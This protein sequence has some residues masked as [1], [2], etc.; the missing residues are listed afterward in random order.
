[1]RIPLDRQSD[2]PL[3]RQIEAFLRQGILSGSLPTDTRLPASR[4][5][6]GDL[7]VNRITV[8]N[9]YAELEADGLIAS[10]VGS[11]TYVLS[12]YPLLPQTSDEHRAS[13]PLWQQDVLARSE[14]ARRTTP[15]AMLKAAGHPHP[16]NFASGIGDPHLFPVKDFRKVI[17]TVLQRDDITAL[18]YGENNGYAPLRSTIA[19]IL[20]N[21]GLQVSPGNVMITS[22]SQQALAL[23]AQ[24]LLRPGDV[25]L[26]ESPTHGGVLGLFRFLDLK[27]VGIPTDENGMQVEKL[28]R[29][30][31][32]HHPRL[33]YT[34]P[35]FHNPT[36]V[37]MSGQRR[38]QLLALA[39]SY[40]IPILEDDFV[41]D[42]RY[43]GRG[44]PT[45]KALD[46]SGSVIYVSTFS[47]MLMPGLRVGFLVAHGPIYDML[48]EFKRSND[49]ATSSGHWKPMLRLVDTRLICAAAARSTANGAT[50]YWQRSA[51]TCLPTC[52]SF[53]PKVGC[54]SGCGFRTSCQPMPCCRWPAGRVSLLRLE[55][56][57]SWRL[58]AARMPCVSTSLSIRPRTPKKG[59]GGWGEPSSGW[60]LVDE[61]AVAWTSP[62]AR[63]LSAISLS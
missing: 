5:L 33:I 26:V 8:D 21:Q 30:L 9:A 51:S 15:D 55:G 31:Q 60:L 49:V 42:L 29:L 43:E 32:Q 56:T 54:L 11:G 39:D 24:L 35:N 62:Y 12:P 6:A 13:W 19:H 27:I 58:P 25:V 20:A 46:A 34:I 52:M 4:Q 10:R 14:A 57:S 2:I 41:G 59:S 63:Q 36:G 17:Q 48:V 22:G 18:E 3:Y 38:R 61:M 28:E 16:I 53:R 37:C 40:N 50:P 44:Q 45:L 23:V 47:K 1:M 7:G